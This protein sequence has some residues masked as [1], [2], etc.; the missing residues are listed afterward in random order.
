MGNGVLGKGKGWVSP[1]GKLERNYT[2]RKSTIPILCGSVNIG[3]CKGNNMGIFELFSKR[4][5]KIRGEIPDVY[6][7]EEI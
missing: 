4:Q 6:V 3:I 2:D 7:Y 1:R 5:K